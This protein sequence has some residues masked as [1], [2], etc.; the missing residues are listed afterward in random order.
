MVTESIW[1]N[2]VKVVDAGLAVAAA[3][4]PFRA[5]LRDTQDTLTE[6]FEL[7]V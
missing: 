3:S 4:N 5:W 7:P 1:V 6:D 2:E